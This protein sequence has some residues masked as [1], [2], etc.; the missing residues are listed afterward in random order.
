MPPL[1]S[2]DTTP[3]ARAVAY[4]SI[5]AVRFPLMFQQW[6]YITFLHWRMPVSVVRDLVPPSL[7]V[8]EFDGSA[9]VGVTPF[10]LRG[11][12]APFVPPLPWLSHFPETNCRTYVIGP[13]GRPAIWFFSLDAARVLAV[14]GAR[15]GYGLPY[16]W[17]RMR[18]GFDRRIRYRSARRWPDRGA[19]TDIEVEP[20]PP[21]EAGPREIFLTARFRLYSVRAGRLVFADVEHPPWPLQAAR[22][23]RA[24]QT[25]TQSSGL[26]APS[27]L[28]LAHFSPGV[29]VR[30][31]WPKTAV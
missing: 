1:L 8:D 5:P 6:R 23:I 21:I 16:A 17:A 14:M 22:V 25:L 31:G 7:T 30:I 26:P 18:I 28:P 15:V 10:L 29:T 20:G 9:W 19:T 3:S 27:G 13:D 12:R 4:P 2:G 11:L 24:E